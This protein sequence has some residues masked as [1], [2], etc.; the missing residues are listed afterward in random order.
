MAVEAAQSGLGEHFDLKAMQQMLQ[1]QAT[2]EWPK[3]GRTDLDFYLESGYVSA[4]A[5]DHRWHGWRS[6]C[7]SI[8]LCSGL[9]V[10]LLVLPVLLYMRLFSMCT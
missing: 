1:Q 7:L 3:N 9:H 6:L 5:N 8:C 4:E 2:Q 10:C